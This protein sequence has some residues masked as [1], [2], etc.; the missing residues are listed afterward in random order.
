M[1]NGIY[2]MKLEH[3]YSKQQD[4][5]MLC[6]AE[7]GDLLE[8]R[9]ARKGVD[10]KASAFSGWIVLEYPTEEDLLTIFPTSVR[11]TRMGD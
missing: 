1:A 5:W 6:N 2:A 8:H 9:P 3:W 7:T 4:C 11:S 10:L